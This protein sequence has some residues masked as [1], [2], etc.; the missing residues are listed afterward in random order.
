MPAQIRCLF[1]PCHFPA[2]YYY[3]RSCF[4]ILRR[5]FRHHSLLSLLSPHNLAK[6][7][8]LRLQCSMKSGFRS[9]EAGSNQYTI[10]ICTGTWISAT[11]P[12]S[13]LNTMTREFLWGSLSM[14]QATLFLWPPSSHKIFLSGAFPALLSLGLESSAQPGERTEDSRLSKACW[15]IWCKTGWLVCLPGSLPGLQSSWENNLFLSLGQ[16]G[17]SLA[18]RIS[19][20]D[21]WHS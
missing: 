5:Q 10:Q 11:F 14:L 18:W 4:P 19:V 17:K 7:L 21:I 12:S 3:Y 20:A 8:V 9:D 15:I 16:G 1:P 6:P 13:S 2:Q